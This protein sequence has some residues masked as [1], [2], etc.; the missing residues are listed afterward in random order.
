MLPKF[1]FVNLDRCNDRLD[2]MNI[3]FKKLQ[4]RTNLPVRYQ[5]IQALDA[6]NSDISKLCNLSLDDMW[7]IRDKK[8]ASLGEFGCTYSHIKGM[9]EFISDKNNTDDY[10]IICEDDIDLF[11]INPQF[12]V[13]MMKNIILHVIKTDLISLSCVGSPLLVNQL[14]DKIKSPVFVDYNSNKGSLYGTGCYIITR[15]LATKIVANHWKNNMLYIP[16]N[17]VSMAADHFIYPQTEATSFMIPSLFTIKLDNDSHIHCDH[18]FMHD[19]VQK[20]M[21]EI[22]KKLNLAIIDTLSIISNNDWGKQYFKDDSKINTP[23][24]STY[25]TPNDYI[26]FLENFDESIKI[27]P[28]KK[29]KSNTCYPVGLI[30]LENELS[31]SIHFT[32]ERDWDISVKNWEDRKKQLPNKSN[33]LFKFCDR[34][35][36]GKFTENLLERFIKLDLP[37]KVIF[38]SEYFKYTNKDIIKNK[39]VR[40]IPKN[41]SDADK[42]S[43]PNGSKLYQICSV[44]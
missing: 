6:I 21:Y 27:T 42:E 43:S 23:T 26:L 34:E 40:T 8:K 14:V 33:I 19:N 10:A 18:V 22:W 13:D 2:H 11:K 5:K 25:F 41:L 37:R 9:Q 7:H 31:I 24:I 29:E 36:K 12:M 16:D 1:Y 35:F 28:V 3:F 32:Q 17:H 39:I 20:M 44:I 38:I 30:N 4:H 15:K